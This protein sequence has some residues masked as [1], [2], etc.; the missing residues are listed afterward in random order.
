[1]KR[2]LAAT[3]IALALASSTIAEENPL[4]KPPPPANPWT[5]ADGKDRIFIAWKAVTCD[6]AMANV[7]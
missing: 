4:A 7:A 6:A 1:M 3:A 2:I 5:A